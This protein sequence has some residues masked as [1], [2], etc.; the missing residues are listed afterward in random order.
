M[1]INFPLIE[2]AYRFAIEFMPI[3]LTPPYLVFVDKYGRMRFFVTQ[4]TLNN[5]KSNVNEKVMDTPKK[6]DNYSL[7]DKILQLLKE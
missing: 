5:V 2:N 4:E 7:E 1:P 3:R 6:P